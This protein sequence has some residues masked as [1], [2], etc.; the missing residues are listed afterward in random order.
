M[1]S[2]IA[3]EARGWC[4]R[5]GSSGRS[6]RISAVPLSQFL[7][8]ACSPGCPWTCPCII[9]Y[10]PHLHLAFYSVCLLFFSSLIRTLV[11]AC[12]VY[13]NQGHLISRS[14]DTSAKTPSPNKVPFIVV[15]GHIFKE[16]PV[17]CSTGGCEKQLIPV[18]T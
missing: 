12:R 7:M 16:A 8:A 5:T 4:V 11:I 6:E 2:P 17:P 14:L 18:A 3:L 10:L 15:G 13:P 9:P 1:Y